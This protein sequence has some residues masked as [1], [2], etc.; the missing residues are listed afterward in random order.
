MTRRT[1][2]LVLLLC[3]GLLGS[4]H[5]E[6]DNGEATTT[7]TATDSS[8]FFYTPPPDEDDD[9]SANGTVLID[10]EMILT[11]TMLRWIPGGISIGVF[12]IIT[13][14]SS[15]NEYY[16][17]KNEVEAKAK[18]ERESKGVP[19]IDANLFEIDVIGKLKTKRG[20]GKSLFQRHMNHAKNKKFEVY[21]RLMAQYQQQIVAKKIWEEKHAEMV[22][23]REGKDTEI[24][25]RKEEKKA[26][27]ASLL[28]PG[29]DAGCKMLANM[30]N[31][32]SPKE[33]RKEMTEVGEEIS[34]AGSSFESQDNRDPDSCLL[35]IPTNL[36]PGIKLNDNRHDDPSYKP[37]TL[38]PPRY[39]K[40]SFSTEVSMEENDDEIILTIRP[41]EYRPQVTVSTENFLD[42]PEEEEEE[43]V[44]KRYLRDVPSVGLYQSTEIRDGEFG[45]S[46][47]LVDMNKGMQTDEEEESDKR[48]NKRSTWHQASFSKIDEEVKL[49]DGTEEADKMES[50]I[51]DYVQKAMATHE[52]EEEEEED[53]VFLQRQRSRVPPPKRKSRPKTWSSTSASENYP[54]AWATHDKTITD[55][56]AK[57]LDLGPPR[58]PEE[59]PQQSAPKVPTPPRARRPS[60]MYSKNDEDQMLEELERRM[61]ENVQGQDDDEIATDNVEFLEKLLNDIAQFG[62]SYSGTPSDEPG[63]K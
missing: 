58:S 36:P 50:M 25:R 40:P 9:T 42:E 6:E 37:I 29:S 22:K 10:D 7:A 16:T 8:D 31:K 54:W 18:K 24:Q 57:F 43:D 23:E 56:I 35:T 63:K 1:V 17:A 33:G 53:D 55:M 20:T 46:I 44:Q 3:G 62:K 27:T 12:V 14:L 48:K 38:Q 13:I 59:M 28:K 41:Q 61:I 45:E 2:Y 26:Y 19:E 30:A 51:D 49:G 34:T 5:G 11:S 39:D 21:N 47:P 32:V 60:S 15:V 4:A 52:S